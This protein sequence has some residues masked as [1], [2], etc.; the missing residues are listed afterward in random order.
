MFA[1]KNH[2][3]NRSNKGENVRKYLKHKESKNGKDGT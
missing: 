1:I 3:M 2:A